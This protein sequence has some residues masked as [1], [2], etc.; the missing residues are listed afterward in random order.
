MVIVNVEDRAIAVFDNST[1]MERYG[2]TKEELLKKKSWETMLKRL[3]NGEKEVGGFK[4]EY[5]TQFFT[6]ISDGSELA[7]TKLK[8]AEA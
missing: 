7:K 1:G 8:Q 3:Q 5:S 6:V 4:L 2:M